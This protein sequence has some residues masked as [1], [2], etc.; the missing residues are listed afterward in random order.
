MSPILYYNYNNLLKYNQC[1]IINFLCLWL[2]FY[3]RIIMGV[4]IMDNI[5]EELELLNEL[6]EIL[7]T[8][9]EEGKNDEDEKWRTFSV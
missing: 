6:D 9:E 4:A 5:K 2:Y 8:M 3:D 1:K 7:T